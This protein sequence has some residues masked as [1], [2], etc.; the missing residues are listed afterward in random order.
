[1]QFIVMG[2]D[3]PNALDRRMAARQAHI[4]TCNK[5]KQDGTMLYGA[6]L[7]DEAGQMKGSMIVLDVADRAA[8]DAYLKDEPY[9]TGDVWGKVEVTPCKI[10]PSFAK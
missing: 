7:L 4:D 9:I 10:G 6:A 8:V 3:H 5:M 2:Y 1:M